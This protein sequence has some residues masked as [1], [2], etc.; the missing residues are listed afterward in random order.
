MP[1][2]I[3]GP[4]TIEAAGSKPK[5][6]H[7]YIGHVNSGHAALSVAHMESPEGWVEPCQ[8]PEFEEITVILKGRVRLDFEGGFLEAEAGQAVVSQPGEWIRYSTPAPGGAEYIA[9][10]LPAFSPDIVHRDAE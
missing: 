2:L 8:R 5:K 9:I 7:E 3:E 4:T 1:R 6:I 10:C